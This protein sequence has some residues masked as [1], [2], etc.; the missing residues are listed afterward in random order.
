LG[1]SRLSFQ[2]FEMAPRRIRGAI[3]V[4]NARLAHRPIRSGDDGCV[5]SLQ[6]FAIDTRAQP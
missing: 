3:F 2:L 1:L 6:V 5:P 4:F